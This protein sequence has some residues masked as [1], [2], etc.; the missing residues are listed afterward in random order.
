[1]S[2]AFLRR[3]DDEGLRR[4]AAISIRVDGAEVLAYEGESV[5]AALLVSGPLAV[6][7]ARGGVARGV[8]CAMGVCFECLVIVDGIPNTR[9]CV[10]WVRDGLEVQ[11]QEGS[12]QPWHPGP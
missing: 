5:A 10:T 9:A 11:G 6:R 8:Y 7:R 2:A 3:R 12:G 1:M 4:G